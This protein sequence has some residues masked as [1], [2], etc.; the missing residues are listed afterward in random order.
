[1]AKGVV[2]K[3][4]EPETPTEIIASSIVAISEGIKKLRAGR[5]ND[6]ALHLLIQHA[7]PR[8]ISLEDI[9]SVMAGLDNLASY[10]LKSKTK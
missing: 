5:L 1:M 9:R 6:R 10:H 8:K 3:Q 7:A 4:T 2:I